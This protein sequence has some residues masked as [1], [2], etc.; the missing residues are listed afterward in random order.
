MSLEYYTRNGIILPIGLAVCGLCRDKHLRSVDLS[1]S[2]IIPSI[3]PTAEI[4]V[5]DSNTSP[6]SVVPTKRELMS[7]LSP[8]SPSPELLLNTN[9]ACPLAAAPAHPLPKMRQLSTSS[10]KVTS[11]NNGDVQVQ[12]VA[13][14]PPQ[15]R[16]KLGM[17][18]I[19]WVPTSEIWKLNLRLEALGVRSGNEHKWWKFMI[20]FTRQCRLVAI[21][22]NM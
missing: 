7:T 2:R 15:D 11:T 4:I 1:N 12:L 22:K 3:S 16:I 17:Y 8:S 6:V 21:K 20:F 13:M 18:C 14:S 5:P 9:N 10:S 19:H